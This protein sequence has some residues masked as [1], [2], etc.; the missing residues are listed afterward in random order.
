M[1]KYLIFLIVSFVFIGC[2]YKNGEYYTP[3]SNNTTY[4]EKGD[5]CLCNMLY[6]DY[7]EALKKGD[8][9]EFKEKLEIYRYNCVK[10]SCQA[11]E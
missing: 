2:G 1:K 9:T 5:S 7:L 8:Q 6:N 4:V 3:L 11:E 10:E